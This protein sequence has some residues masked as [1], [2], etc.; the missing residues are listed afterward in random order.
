MSNNTYVIP[1]LGGQ[2]RIGAFMAPD[3]GGMIL[4]GNALGVSFRE[5]GPL[6]IV[7]M[8]ELSTRLNFIE[9]DKGNFIGGGLRITGGVNYYHQK[10]TFGD[11]LMPYVSFNVGKG[12][13]TSVKLGAGLGVRLTSNDDA[14]TNVALSVG[15]E[16]IESVDGMNYHSDAAVL[17]IGGAFDLFSSV[18][19][20]FGGQ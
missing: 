8:P 10:Q 12:E 1:Y 2:F 18:Q 5:V 13:S 20:S 15:Y 11:R 17:H 9:A 4:E 3:A 14:L 19:R 7:V 16:R 6:D